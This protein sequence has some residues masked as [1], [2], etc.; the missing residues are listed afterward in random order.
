MLLIL[1]VATILVGAIVGG[2]SGKL[3]L[4]AL[5]KSQMEA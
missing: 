1:L 5:E 2:M 4:L 3:V